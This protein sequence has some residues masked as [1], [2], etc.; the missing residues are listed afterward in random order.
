MVTNH[1]S[2]SNTYAPVVEFDHAGK[3]YRFKD[4]V[5]SNPPSYRTGQ[6]VGVLYDPADPRDARIDRG[7]WNKVV[8]ILSGGCGALFVLLGLWILQ[9]RGGYRA[10]LTRA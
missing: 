10:S 1:S 7:R 5:S 2:D 6:R 8:P 9:R 4:S 3:K